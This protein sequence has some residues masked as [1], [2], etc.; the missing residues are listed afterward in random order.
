MLGLA[1]GC[2]LLCWKVGGGD[3][4]D[5]KAAEGAKGVARC[6]AAGIFQGAAFVRGSKQP[7]EGVQS[8]CSWG[9]GKRAFPHS[10]RRNREQPG[11]P[12]RLDWWSSCRVEDANFQFSVE[13]VES[14]VTPSLHSPA[15]KEGCKS[16]DLLRDSSL[17]PFNRK[18]LF[19]L[20][21][22][23]MH[24]GPDRTKHG[25]RIS[26]WELEVLL[27]RGWCKCCKRLCLSVWKGKSQVL[28]TV[29]DNWSFTYLASSEC[30]GLSDYGVRKRWTGYENLFMALGK[31]WN[32]RNRYF[33]SSN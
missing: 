33:C 31:Q 14:S 18:N 9:P 2:C 12:W 28:Q 26:L 23:H 10:R 29:Q 4:G 6:L 25:F 15:L 5:W 32:R 21:Y 24:P 27:Y 13:L 11:A 8:S 22:V 30:W 7:Q 1:P 19:H 20:A 3:S 17:P 16:P